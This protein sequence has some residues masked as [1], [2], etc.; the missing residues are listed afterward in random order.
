MIAAARNGE[1]DAVLSQVKRPRCR[2]RRPLRK[3]GFSDV[4]DEMSTLSRQ[5]FWLSKVPEQANP[6]AEGL[7]PADQN[8]YH[9]GQPWGG[10]EAAH[11][12]NEG[13]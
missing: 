7:R 3:I 6:W 13:E 8:R 5:S 1:L 9:V 10:H 11:S 12:D 2:R 4:I